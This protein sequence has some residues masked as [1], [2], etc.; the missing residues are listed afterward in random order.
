MDRYCVAC[1]PCRCTR[2]APATAWCGCARR[3]AAGCAWAACWCTW[4]SRGRRWQRRERT[5]RGSYEKVQS[6]NLQPKVTHVATKAL[7]ATSGL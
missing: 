2:S 4:A 3:R 7:S 1:E 5:C 6:S